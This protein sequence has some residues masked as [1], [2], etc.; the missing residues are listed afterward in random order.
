MR[1]PTLFCLVAYQTIAWFGTAAGFATNLLGRSGCMVELDTTEV[2]MNHPVQPAP[3]DGMEIVVLPEG[4]HR[5]VVLP[6]DTS[7]PV[8]FLL[9]L[10]S[11]VHQRFQFVMDASPGAYF[12]KGGCEGQRR[13]SG[14]AKDTVNVIVTQSGAQ[15]WAGWAR[16][17]E[18]V[19][20]THPLV[21][22][23]EQDTEEDET[24][25]ILSEDSLSSDEACE[26]IDVAQADEIHGHVVHSTDHVLAVYGRA[27]GSTLPAELTLRFPLN[28]PRDRLLLETTEG[29][30]FE[31]GF[32]DGQRVLVSPPED[33]DADFSVAITL[34]E[35]RAIHVYG[36]YE[37][38]GK[39][40]RLEPLKLSW[41]RPEHVVDPQKKIDEELAQ[42][43]HGVKEQAA[44][45][46][47]QKLQ[48]EYQDEEGRQLHERKERQE[49]KPLKER[50]TDPAMFSISRHY[51]LAIGIF[52]G[53]NLILVQC[54]LSASRRHGAKGRREL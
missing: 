18:A 29:A 31:Q 4:H 38:E 52:L 22:M 19:T 6:A 11:P 20:L 1:I 32:C 42:L 7:F 10:Q 47:Q 15:V 35:E 46:R 50:P 41:T 13:I 36:I 3:D 14:D 40:Y 30:S 24:E 21:F 51:Y 28:V 26:T 8:T 48:R 25:E 2:I 33:D 23:L 49:R 16:E 17:H 43:Q 39:L 53:A 9:Q 27:M 44:R 37:N 12:P 54:C 5:E 34:L 45:Y